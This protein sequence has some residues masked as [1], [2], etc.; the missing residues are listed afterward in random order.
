MDIKEKV[1][2]DLPENYKVDF[3]KIMKYSNNTSVVEFLRK[4][5]GDAPLNHSFYRFGLNDI[6]YKKDGIFKHIEFYRIVDIIKDRD[7]GYGYMLKGL[8]SD[9]EIIDFVQDAFVERVD[10]I[11]GY[12]QDKSLADISQ[13]VRQCKIM[14]SNAFDDGIIYTGSD[15]N[16]YLFFLSKYNET[17]K[18]TK[19]GTLHDGAKCII[20]PSKELY[21]LYPLDPMLAWEAFRVSPN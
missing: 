4:Y 19:Y 18:T 5:F 13:Y 20:W 14:Y 2:K 17:I 3:A 21:E 9:K 1:F 16:G 11:C 10:S 7:L 15:E 8:S 6:V 12:Y